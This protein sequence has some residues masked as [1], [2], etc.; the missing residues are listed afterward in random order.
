MAPN[1][2]QSD[3]GLRAF[4]ITVASVGI[5]FYSGR[6]SACERDPM[7]TQKAR[8][9]QRSGLLFYNNQF[10]RDLTLRDHH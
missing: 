8:E 10:S 3:E 7:M 1:P 4:G 2:S 5:S 9:I 6:R